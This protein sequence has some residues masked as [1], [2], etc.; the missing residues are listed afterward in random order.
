[1]KLA[2]LHLVL[3]VAL[4]ATLLRVANCQGSFLRLYVV[5]GL[6]SPLLKPLTAVGV[7]GRV[8][9]CGG[10]IP[11][12][13]LFSSPGYPAHISADVSLRSRS[14]A[15][16]QQRLAGSQRVA[17]PSISEPTLIDGGVSSLNSRRGTPRP[18][19]GA[20]VCALIQRPRLCCVCIV[21]GPVFLLSLTSHLSIVQLHASH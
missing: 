5:R 20:E 2:L 13:P 11:Q 1:M 14:N 8:A 18:A 9:M 7:V 3:A 16:I 4:C 17:G 15:H 10:A 19:L 6:S 21:C 12:L